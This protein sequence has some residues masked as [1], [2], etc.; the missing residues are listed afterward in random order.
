M[1]NMVVNLD[2]D[3][4]CIG[5]KVM[6]LLSHINKRAKPNTSIKLPFEALVKQ[7]VDDQV[8]IFVKNFTIIYLEMCVERMTPEETVQHIPSFLKGIARR[9]ESQRTAIFHMVLP[10]SI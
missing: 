7:L 5:N 6:E 3:S 9:P 8:S 4:R 1:L 2:S 10:V